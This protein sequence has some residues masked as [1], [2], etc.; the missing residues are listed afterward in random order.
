MPKQRVAPNPNVAL[1]LA[2]LMAVR[3]DVSSQLSLARKSGVGQTTIGRI[4]RG[5]VDPQAENLK[6]LA[7]ALDCDVSVLFWSNERLRNTIEAG[8]PLRHAPSEP[9]SERISHAVAEPES[10]YFDNRRHQT[11]IDLFEALPSKEQ[12]EL[13]RNLTEKK[14]HYA[15]LLN[16][17][18]SKKISNA[19]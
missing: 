5:E 1:N 18:L 13:I 7:D 10:E 6:K 2:S 9:I 12:D 3:P 8:H 14:Q 15:E 11:L 17:L 4:L 16:E 19:G